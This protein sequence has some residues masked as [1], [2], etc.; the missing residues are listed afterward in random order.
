MNRQTYWREIAAKRPSET[1]DLRE[2]V[3]A[4]WHLI[5]R[6]TRQALLEAYACNGLFDHQPGIRLIAAFITKDSSSGFVKKIRD[7]IR[8]R[9]T[10]REVRELLR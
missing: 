10:Q 1:V 2:L 8:E 9:E 4:L 7:L 3:K 6:S 5:D